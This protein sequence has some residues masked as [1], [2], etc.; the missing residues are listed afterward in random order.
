MAQFNAAN[1]QQ[2]N[3]ANQAAGLQG[4]QFRLGAAQ[5]L[6]TQG[7][8][9]QANQFANAQAMMGLGQQRQAFSQQQLDAARNLGLERLGIMQG[10][11]GLQPA[12]LGGTTSQPYY[13]NT[14]ANV[15][16]GALGGASLAGMIPGMSAGLG[17]GMGALLGLI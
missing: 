8:A 1:M 7:A 2:A 4:A 9:Q 15:L 11:L 3:L 10:A 12:N 6:G 5:Q 14:G 16:G 17:A 13:Q